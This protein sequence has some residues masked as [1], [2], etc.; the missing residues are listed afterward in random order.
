MAAFE[1]IGSGIDGL[2]NTLDYIRLGDNVVWQVTDLEDFRFFVEPFV[3][4]AI[5][6][7]RNVVYIRFAEHEPV[8]CETEG[9]KVYV[10]DTAT[11]FESFTVALHGIIA[12]EGR[13]AFYV[14]DS[15]SELQVA[16]STDLM[17]GNFF[18]VTCPYLFE[19]DTVAY[20]PV[21]RGRHSYEAIARIRETTQL[22]LDVYSHN[23]VLYL[24]PLKVWNRY[25]S[26]MFLPHRLEKDGSFPAITNGVEVGEFY[27]ILHSKSV[28]RGEQNLDSYERFLQNAREACNANK[29]DKQTCR[30]ITKSMLTH[31]KKMALLIEKHFDFT[32]YFKIKD[33]M[34]GT[35]S[36]GGKACGMLLARKICEKT[37]KGYTEHSE[38]HDSFYIGTDVFYSYLVENGY[39]K[40]RLEQK[41]EKGYFAVGEEL[42]E[43]ILKGSFSENI[44]EQLRR[45]LE[46]FGQ[47]PIIVRSS[48]F[49]EDGFGN[50]FAGKYESVFCV[51]ASPPEER[52]VALE[53]AIKIVYA[54]TMDRSA[55]EY[56][57]NRKLQKSDEQMAILVQRVSGTRF[58]DY[59]Y[60]CAAGVGFSY[61]LYRWS[62][63]LSP[64]AGMLR[65]VSGMGTRAVDRTEGDYP[66]LVNLDKPE[67]T[68]FTE[69]ADKHRFSQHKLDV[70][71]FWQNKI[72]E[73][74]LNELINDFPQ[75]YINLIL[76]HD[77]EAE[78]L[79]RQRGESRDIYFVSCQGIVKNTVFID[80]MKSLLNTLEDSYGCPVD[81]EYTVNFNKNGDFLINLLQCRPLTVW[82]N[83]AAVNIPDIPH[84]NK[85]FEVKSSFMGSSVKEGIDVIVIIKS[86]KYYKYPYT[87]KSGITG[88]LDRINTYYKNSG[89]KLLLLTPGRIGTSS[90]ELGVP[91]GF[92]N[93]NAFSVICEY[94]DSTTGYMPELSYG[95]HMF[96]DLVEAD[97]FYVAVFDDN[98]TLAFNRSLFDNE[99][100]RFP[101]I[102]ESM[103][104]FSDIISV[105]ELTDKKLMLFADIDNRRT[106]CG[107]LPE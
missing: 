62:D 70:V 92:A 107:L 9:L 47:S 85:L 79:F 6:D 50:A 24:H 25:S 11:G 1:R 15:L 58:G 16:W 32:D 5:A 81:I 21:L 91:A 40:L 33:R 12:R 76:E 83:S 38:T 46:Y 44:R 49:L 103:T 18:R 57:K 56:R 29:L 104:D 73:K 77:R 39:W 48:S 101:L 28:F 87:K 63:E 88:A 86:D 95:S 42:R 19:L 90:P 67:S 31:D 52:L 96:L 45:L 14:F 97:M 99:Q 34:I 43:L 64:D 54:S 37:V 93:I 36:I 80:L 4:R 59:F 82:K 98:R 74:G 23:G 8:V 72:A 20:F 53:R 69:T 10:L 84:K 30:K 51:N 26:D 78:E 89:K 35:G 13:D 2:D 94:S 106:L 60:P 7:G 68:V 27:S 61:S 105:V 102:A 17:M 65:L 66:R 71:D 3:R 100:N 41:T 55:L 22:L 75:W